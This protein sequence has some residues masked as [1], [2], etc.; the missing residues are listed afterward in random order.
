MAKAQKAKGKKRARKTPECVVLPDPSEEAESF[1][2]DAYDL[3]NRYE[4]VE[5]DDFGDV[6]DEEKLI[7]W[8]NHI[9][10]ELEVLADDGWEG[11]RDAMDAL[12]NRLWKIGIAW[13]QHIP[14]SWA[15][16][17]YPEDLKKKISET[18]LYRDDLLAIRRYGDRIL[19]RFKDTV[20][21]LV[22]HA[23]KTIKNFP[24]AEPPKAKGKKKL[25]YKRCA[26]K[27]PRKILR[28]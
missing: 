13:P 17:V 24:Q 25:S 19:C 3:I 20:H 12:S 1:V 8:L 15:D 22:E 14:C 2:A 16:E 23:R 5:E 6:V 9:R 11:Y 27:V 21:L 28:K 26:A 10:G 7:E 4:C 18:A